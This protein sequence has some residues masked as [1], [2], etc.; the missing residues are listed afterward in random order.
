MKKLAILFNLIS[1]GFCL[2]LF[3]SGTFSLAN[4]RLV[5][6]LFL[7]IWIIAPLINLYYLILFDKHKLKLINENSWLGL[8]LKRKIM[9]EK[10]KIKEL[11]K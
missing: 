1:L 9:E 2:F 3:I 7:G 5:D 6:L 10:K 4:V 11:E 8:F